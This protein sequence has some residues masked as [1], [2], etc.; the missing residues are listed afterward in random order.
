M[1]WDIGVVAVELTDSDEFEKRCA[2]LVS[3]GYK[4]SSSC[5][6]FAN[7]EAYNFCSSWQAIFVLPRVLATT[8]EAVER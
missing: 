7:S 2:E 4:L 1:T 3:Q 8:K 6:G 5:C